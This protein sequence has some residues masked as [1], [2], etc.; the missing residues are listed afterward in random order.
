VLFKNVVGPLTR[1]TICIIAVVLSSTVNSLKNGT[2]PALFVY[3]KTMILIDLAKEEYTIYKKFVDTIKVH[4]A[5]DTV[6]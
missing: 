5:H 2:K 3:R 4:K 6:V 1:N